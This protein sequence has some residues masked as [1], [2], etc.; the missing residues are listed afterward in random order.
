[1]VE[2]LVSG[3]VT[4]KY[5]YGLE[6][7]SELQMVNGTATASF[8]QYDGRGTVRMLTNSAGVVTDTYEYDFFGNRA[9]STGTTPNE[10]YYRGD[11]W[12]RIRAFTVIR[13]R[14][15]Q[16]A[17]ASA[18]HF[19]ILPT[20]LCPIHRGFIAMSGRDGFKM[21]SCPPD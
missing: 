7:I 8:Y 10:Y 6:R 16:V 5:T 18:S 9:N 14:Y 17:Q 3:Q 2:E 1:V 19:R 11:S 13:K 20:Q 15:R 12:S 4:R 21:I